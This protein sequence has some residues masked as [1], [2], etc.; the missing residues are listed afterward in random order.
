MPALFLTVR[1]N[2]SVFPMSI[3]IKEE[4]DQQVR[5]RRVKTL[6]QQRKVHVV[7]FEMVYR[8]GEV[9]RLFEWFNDVEWE[10]TRIGEGADFLGAAV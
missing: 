5:E 4:L 10:K 1:L 8:D 9:V 2:H 7:P 3:D 6:L